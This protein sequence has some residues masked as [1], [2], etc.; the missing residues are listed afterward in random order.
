MCMH[1]II[2]YNIAYNYKALETNQ[3]P[4]YRI[5]EKIAVLCNLNKEEKD[6]IHKINILCKNIK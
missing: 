6:F 1:H 4:V 5:A 2:H 3:I